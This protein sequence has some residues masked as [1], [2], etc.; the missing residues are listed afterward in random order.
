MLAVRGGVSRSLAMSTK[1][2]PGSPEPLPASSAGAAP[3]PPSVLRV[4]TALL[5]AGAAEAAAGIRVLDQA[6]RTAA[7]AAAALGCAVGAIAS[8]LVFR[9]ED[10]GVRAEGD[11]AGGVRAEGDRAEGDRAEGEVQGAGDD[12]VLVL[13]SGAHRVD[14]DR[15]AALLGLASLGRADADLV[16]DRTGFAIGGVAPVGHAPTLRTVVDVALADHPRVWAAAG[17]PHAVFPTT[18]DELVAITGGTPAEVASSPS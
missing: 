7:Q 15:V 10:G 9:V 2:T 11:R 3:L 16:R 8:S 5:V 6:A 14:T 4:Q 12:V 18:Y 13:T 1:S 17:H